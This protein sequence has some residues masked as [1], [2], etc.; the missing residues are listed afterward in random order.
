MEITLTTPAILFPA[1]SLLML[2]YTNRFLT[3][4]SIVRSLV[5]QNIEI[6]DSNLERQIQNLNL[7]IRLI[8][9][10]QA[11]GSLSL[12]VCVMSILLLYLEW[13]GLGKVMFGVALLLMS[14]SLALSFWEIMLS[15]EALKLEL[16]RCQKKNKQ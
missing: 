3:L 4:A 2:A 10:M 6:E 12:F 14:L 13:M 15:G 11:A 8:K 7:R 1:I 5:H 16:E 9:G